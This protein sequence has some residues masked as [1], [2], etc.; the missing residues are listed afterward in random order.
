MRK[1]IFITLSSLAL[2]LVTYIIRQGI[3]DRVDRILSAFVFD[4]A[5]NNLGRV[6]IYVAAYNTYVEEYD[7]KSKFFGGEYQVL[8]AHDR[9]VAAESELLS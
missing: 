8:D 4:D 9:P 7:L 3:R 5:S 6:M 1:L 2:L